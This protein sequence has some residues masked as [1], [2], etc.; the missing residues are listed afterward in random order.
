MISRG[1]VATN[2]LIKGWVVSQYSL[3]LET[4]VI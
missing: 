3:I 4:I 2:E 1:S